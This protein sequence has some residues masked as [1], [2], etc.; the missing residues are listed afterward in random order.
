MCA[1][2]IFFDAYFGL[3]APKLLLIDIDFVPMD[4]GGDA[5]FTGNALADERENQCFSEI[6]YYSGNKCSSFY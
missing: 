1:N 2:I 4:G 5:D 3:T 6:E